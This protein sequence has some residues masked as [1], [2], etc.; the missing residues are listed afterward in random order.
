LTR[1]GV[2]G[3]LY[4]TVGIVLS[5]VLVLALFYLV[6]LITARRAV[7]RLISLGEWFVV[8]IPFVKFFYKTTKQIVDTIAVSTSGALQRV[9]IIEYPRK[10]IRTVAFM[11][12]ETRIDGEQEPYINLFVPTTPNPTSGYMII[13][14]ASQVMD[15]NMTIEEGVKFIVSGGI[16]P[17]A[18]LQMRPFEVYSVE[19]TE[20]PVAETM[21]PSS[22]ETE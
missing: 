21:Q 15:T 3:A 19:T 8:R 16:L 18:R 22:R 2:E 13:L 11:T 9:V 10:G 17:P 6:G 14:P 20:E 4:N 7:R 12:G 1:L 5:L